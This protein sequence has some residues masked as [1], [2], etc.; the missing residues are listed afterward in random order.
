MILKGGRS[1]YGQSRR[2]RYRLK[3]VRAEAIAAGCKAGV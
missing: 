3:L 1:E 2:G